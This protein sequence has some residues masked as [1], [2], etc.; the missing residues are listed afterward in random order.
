M[1]G[2]ADRI[3]R[4]VHTCEKGQWVCAPKDFLDLGSRAAVD[5]ALSRLIRKGQLR[6]VGRGLY[7]CP[8]ISRILKQPAPVDLDAVVKAL[9][10]RYKVCLMPDGLVD[11]NRLGLTNAV[12]ARASYWT[13]GASR[14]IK[15]EGLT[16]IRF[17]HVSR[18]I[19]QWQDKSASPVV[20]ALYWLGPVVAQNGQVVPALQ[21]CLPEAVKQNLRQYRTD[22]P[23]WM[24]P[25]AHSLTAEPV[26]PA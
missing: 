22:L 15:I 12:P 26:T 4:R 17:R 14:I 21:R 2:V 25:L 13:N 3:M 1:A 7:D 5:Q 10:K 20:R 9:A 23:D 16:T 11:A 18:R 24:V 19:M 8:R 6:R